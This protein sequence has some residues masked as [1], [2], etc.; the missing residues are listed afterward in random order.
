MHWSRVACLCLG[1]KGG[2]VGAHIYLDFVYVKGYFAFGVKK[3]LVCKKGNLRT[4]KGPFTHA[5][6]K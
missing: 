2:G 5:K 1:V 6:T 3:Y 4:Q